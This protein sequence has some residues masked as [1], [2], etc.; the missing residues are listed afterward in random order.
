[1]SLIFK[2]QF[3]TPKIHIHTLLPTGRRRKKIERLLKDLSDRG[4]WF[5]SS[6]DG[7]GGRSAEEEVRNEK[8]GKK[9]EGKDRS[10]H[11]DYKQLYQGL[12]LALPPPNK[13]KKQASLFLRQK[14]KK[15]KT[16]SPVSL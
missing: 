5:R 15:K 4:T 11:G 16:A 14:K 7:E 13:T 9:G 2:F 3:H 12:S 10:G 8:E 6:D 1:M